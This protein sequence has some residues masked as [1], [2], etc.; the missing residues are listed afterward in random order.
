M[1]IGSYTITLRQI[2]LVL[3]AICGWGVVYVLQQ[4]DFTRMQ[5]I[6][7]LY[8][9]GHIEVGDYWRFSINKIIRFTLNDLLSVL[10]IYGIFQERKYVRLAFGVM[11]LGLFLLLPTYLIANYLMGVEGFHKLQF[12]HRITMN[13]VLMILLIPAIFYDKSQR[14]T[15]SS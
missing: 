5:L 4:F 1:K 3:L 15:A 6:P 2:L 12:L 8:E 11:F 7:G 14:N 9:Q 13:P 10:F